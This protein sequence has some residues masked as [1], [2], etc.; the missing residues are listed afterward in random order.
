LEKT[1]IILAFTIN[2]L[3]KITVLRFLLHGIKSRHSRIESLD[4][5][6]KVNALT[7]LRNAHITL[8]VPTDYTP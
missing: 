8:P 2:V 5:V 7:I 4:A 3:L 6:N 1:F